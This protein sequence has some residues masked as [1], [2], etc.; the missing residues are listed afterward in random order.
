MYLSHSK[1]VCKYLLFLLRKFL[2]EE[3]SCKDTRHVSFTFAAWWGCCPSPRSCAFNMV[4]PLQLQA[5]VTGEM[6]D[7]ANDE[8]SMS[9]RTV[10]AS[11]L[12]GR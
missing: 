5:L 12:R 2:E 10:Q 8:F 7:G 6:A 11:L 3:L 4:G 1:S 9:V